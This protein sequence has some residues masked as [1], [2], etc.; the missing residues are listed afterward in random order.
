MKEKS[1]VARAKEKSLVARATLLVYSHF[2][3]KYYGNLTRRGEED[4]VHSC[5]SAWPVTRG[6]IPTR[7]SHQRDL[8]LLNIFVAKVAFKYCPE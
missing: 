3:V 1:L 8:L 7:M 6:E 5:D 4:N 2:F